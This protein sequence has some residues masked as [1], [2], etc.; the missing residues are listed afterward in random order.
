[1]EGN[2]DSQTNELKKKYS[3]LTDADLRFETGKEDDLIKR[4][5]T[6]LGKNREEVISI[7]RDGQKEKK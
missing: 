2:W 1:M 6:R 5:E 3:N 4:V 7:I